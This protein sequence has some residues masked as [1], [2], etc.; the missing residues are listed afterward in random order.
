[1]GHRLINRA[2]MGTATTGTGT[3]T[4]G[5]AETGYFSFAE[6][7]AA[8]NGIYSYLIED[9]NDFEFGYGTYTVSGTTLSRDKV[10][11]SKIAGTAGTSKINLSG[12]AKV[13]I[14][15]LEQNIHPL[16]DVLAFTSG[17]S[18]N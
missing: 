2:K 9:G 1:M 17:L 6:A 13:A 3:V 14:V 11:A 4:L 12:S 18:Y 8:N 7:G 16:G 15:S 5:S 10:I